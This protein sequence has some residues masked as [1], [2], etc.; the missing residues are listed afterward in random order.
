MTCGSQGRK[1]FWLVLLLAIV[2][3]LP[4]S[5]CSSS[6]SIY[7]SMLKPKGI[8][9]I[10]GEDS[11]VFDATDFGKLKSVVSFEV[12]IKDLDMD[13]DKFVGRALGTDIVLV[14]FPSKFF[15]WHSYEF[16]GEVDGGCYDIRAVQSKKRCRVLLSCEVS[17]K[18]VA[19]CH[20]QVSSQGEMLLS[21][22]SSTKQRLIV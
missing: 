19:K 17:K 14:R 8:K 18:G 4:Y 13:L 12:D 7:W 1:S 21:G 10:E 6:P 20:I 15:G 9:T 16:L 11:E 5:S 3:L 22:Q 2:Q